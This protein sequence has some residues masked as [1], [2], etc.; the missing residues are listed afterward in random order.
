MKLDKLPSIIADSKF[1]EK[2]LVEINGKVLVP[3]YAGSE[4]GFNVPGRHFLYNDF[5]P[6]LEQ[7]CDVLVLCPFQACA[8]YL[9]LPTV[10]NEDI[11]VKKLREAWTKFNKLIGIVN[12]ETLMPKSKLMI[13][14]YDGSHACDDGVCAETAH[15]ATKGYGPVVGIRSD[16]RLDE[17]MA[18]PINPAVRYFIDNGPYNGEFFFGPD[19]YDRA[20]ESIKNM[21]DEIRKR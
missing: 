10:T 1:N 9:D 13:A 7:E 18:A 21:A 6:K 16:F 5:Y 12:Y 14:I 2:G 4:L 17:N 8:E 20:Y 15:Y 11:L 3:A 19:A